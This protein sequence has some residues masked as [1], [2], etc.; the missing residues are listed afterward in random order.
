MKSN[1]EFFQLYQSVNG[2]TV[3]IIDR[4]T[5]DIIG[6][7]EQFINDAR[8][9]GVDISLFRICHRE[10]KDSTVPLNDWIKQNNLGGKIDGGRLYIFKQKPAKWLFVNDVDV[11]II[12]TNSY[13]PVNDYITSHWINSHP[14]V[15][16]ISD[17]T[18]TK[19]RNKQIAVL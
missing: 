13:I 14:C 5:K 12:A 7:L 19:S 10:P 3:L 11:K 8:I 1:Q 6:W 17:I 15:C 2:T 4:N 9:H 18:P 16:Y